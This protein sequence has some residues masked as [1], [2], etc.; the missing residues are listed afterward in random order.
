MAKRLC[1]KAQAG[2]T[3]GDAPGPQSERARLARDFT[4]VRVAGGDTVTVVVDCAACQEQYRPTVDL[5]R[6]I[7]HMSR[8]IGLHRYTTRIACP[9]CS[10]GTNSLLEILVH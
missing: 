9:N 7:R 10:G 5:T 8:Q 3:V 2:N 6:L 4:Y 1:K